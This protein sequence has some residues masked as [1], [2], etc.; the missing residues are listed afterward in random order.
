MRE[1]LARD[2]VQ[3]LDKRGAVFW[4]HPQEHDAVAELRVA[5][6]DLRRD[7]KRAGSIEFQIKAC[8]RRKR[9]HTF[10]VASAEAQVGSSAMYGSC[11]GLGM[12]LDWDTDFESRILA[13]FNHGPTSQSNP[14]HI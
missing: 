4:A 7:D 3:E 2:L 8:A 14:T 6:D 5:G 12:N 9:V 11:A 1:V 13:S 10:D